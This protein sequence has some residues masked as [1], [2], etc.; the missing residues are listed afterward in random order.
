VLK[1]GDHLLV[2]DNAYRPTRNFCNGML[3]RYG[4]ETTYFDP[5]I[6]AGI[7]S[8]SSRTPG[9]CWSKRRARSPSKC[10]TSRPSPPSRMRAA[11]S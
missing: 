7:E 1:A 6:G 5:L 8:C 9:R 4:V 10:P 11:R 2:C 3:A